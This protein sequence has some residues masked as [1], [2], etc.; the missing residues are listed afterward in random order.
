M[1]VCMYV[2]MIVMYVLYIC[3]FIYVCMF[4]IYNVCVFI[5]TYLCMYV[6]MHVN[7]RIS[8][9]VTLYACMYVCMYVCMYAFMCI[10]EKN[11]QTKMLDCRFP[12]PP[13]C[14]ERARRSPPSTADWFRARPQGQWAGRKSPFPAPQDR[15]QGEP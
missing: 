13:E 1:Y 5:L 7:V 10:N 3:T 15:P 9:Q 12:Y 2:S 6:M 11:F 14:T 8:M 4:C